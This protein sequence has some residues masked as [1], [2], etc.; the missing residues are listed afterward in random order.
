MEPSQF[1]GR[2]VLVKA[3]HTGCSSFHVL[4]CIDDDLVIRTV[5]GGLHHNETPKTH[6]VNENVF[7]LLPGARERLV[8]RLDDKGKRSNG[9][10]TCIWASI[11]PSG[12]VNVS[13]RGLG[14][15]LTY[16]SVVICGISHNSFGH[17]NGL[18][19]TRSAAQ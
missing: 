5:T 8:F 6:L 1:F 18:S 17:D 9:P 16:G 11:A 10:I 19:I 14:S 13:G 7:L 12:K 3:D 2:Y 4:Q 15:C